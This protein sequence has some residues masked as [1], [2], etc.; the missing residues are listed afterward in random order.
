MSNSTHNVLVCKC[1]I[2]KA[3]RGEA[4]GNQNSNYGRKWSEEKREH[5]SI[6]RQ[7]TGNP[8]YGKKQTELHRLSICRGNK[9][10]FWKGGVTGLYWMIRNLPEYKVWVS[11]VFSRDDYTCQ[12][13]YKRGG[14]LDAHHI[15]P[16]AQILR[17]FLTHYV[18]FSPVEDKETLVRLALTYEDF[19]KV[20]NGKSLCRKCHDKTKIGV[21]T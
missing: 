6:S 19:W 4:L 8:F 21:R 16:F 12:D 14:R 7:G 18:Q 2:C 9:S 20:S 11:Q 15:K 17:E 5:F 13:C 10:V 3:T 1:C